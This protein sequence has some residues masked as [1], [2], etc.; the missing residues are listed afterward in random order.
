M[1]PVFNLLIAYVVADILFSPDKDSV[2]LSGAVFAVA[3]LLA[4]LAFTYAGVLKEGSSE[5]NRVICGGEYLVESTGLFLTATLLNY[6]SVTIPDHYIRLFHGGR[7]P[8]PDDA[9]FKLTMTWG[10]DLIA[11]FISFLG[12]VSFLKGFVWCGSVVA[13]RE[14]HWPGREGFLF[15]PPKIQDN[16]P[17][18]NDEGPTAP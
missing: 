3:A 12:I 18:Q 5:R 7:P 2:Q 15:H 16:T 9:T 14:R 13:Q 4:G 17:D 6:A 10:V 11:F 8:S 1:F